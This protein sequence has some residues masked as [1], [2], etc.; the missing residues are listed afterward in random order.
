[1]TGRLR[2][3]QYVYTVGT[4]FTLIYLCIHK[5]PQAPQTFLTSHQNGLVTV[6]DV[7]RSNDGLI[8]SNAA[9]YSLPH[10]SG[11]YTRHTG[12]L[13]LQHPSNPSNTSTT[14]Y[15]LSD[16][17]SIHCLDL[18][19]GPVSRI[20]TEGQACEWSADVHSLAEAANIHPD[21]GSLGSQAASEVDLNL[22][23]QSEAI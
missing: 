15:Q 12:H 1:M 14:I 16:R 8:H 19:F 5:C 4:P 17:G 21:A 9:P 22:A 7:S 18:D 20:K 23:Y 6:F 13:L 11:Y 3:G 2:R 10:T